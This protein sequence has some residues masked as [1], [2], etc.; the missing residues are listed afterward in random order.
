MKYIKGILFI[1]F[2]IFQTFQSFSQVFFE[3]DFE[4]DGNLPV[5]WTQEYISENYDWRASPGGHTA[6]PGI[7]GSRKPPAAYE[8][9]YNAMFEKLTLTNSVTRFITPE[10]DLTFAIKAQLRFYHA[11]VERCL[12]SGGCNNDRLKVYG[13]Y[14]DELDNVSWVL[15]KTYEEEVAEWTLRTI[16]IPDSLNQN[17]FQLAFE[18]IIGPGWGMC[19]DSVSVIE[20]GL[21]TRYIEK[22]EVKQA[23]TSYVSS[24]TFK[25]PILR[26]DF[27]IKGN[28]G[29]ITLDSL[30]VESLND[31]G[32]NLS[33]DG[34]QIFASEDTIFRD[35]VKLSES[36]D[37]VG[38]EHWF[39]GIDFSFETGLTSIWLTYDMPETISHDLHGAKLDAMIPAGGIRI[40][41]QAYPAQDASPAGFRI[42]YEALFFDDFETDQGWTFTG[43]FEHDIPQ[44]RGGVNYGAPDPDTAH[45]GQKVIGTDLTGLGN[46][47]GDYENDLE[48]D[49]YEAITPLINTEYFALMQF[50][51][52]R[53]LNIEGF[54]TARI[55]YNLNE[56]G[57]W[58]EIWSNKGVIVEER[59]KDVSILLPDTVNFSSSIRLK[60][61][62]GG[63]DLFSVFSGWNIDD[64][65]LVG[66]YISYDLL[67]TEYIESSCDCNHSGTDQITV[68]VTNRG[69]ETASDIPIGFSLDGGNTW[70]MDQIS[71]DISSSDTITYTF[72]ETADF[73]D[74]G[75]YD[76]MVKTFFQDDE[77]PEN[78]LLEHEQFM[79]YQEA[80]PY[81]ANFETD[82]GRWHIKDGNELWERGVPN[83]DVINETATGNNAWTTQLSFN[84]TNNAYALL[85]GP[86]FD[87]SQLEKP[88]F[89]CK[90]WGQ[91]DDANDGLTLMYSADG[92]Q[93]WQPVPGD[94]YYDWNWYNNGMPGPPGTPAWDTSSSGWVLMRTQL[95]DAFD[96]YDYV[97]FG[98]LFTSD[99][100]G[101]D[102]GFAVDDVAI[103]ESP[104]DFTVESLTYPETSCELPDTTHVKVQIENTSLATAP[105][106]TEIPVRFK[107]QGSEVITDTAVLSEDLLP[108]T[109]YEFLFDT[110]VAMDSAGD[111]N[112]EFITL[113][114]DDPDFYGSNNDTTTAIVSVNGMPRYNPF[115]PFTGK[116][117]GSVDLDAGAGYTTYAWNTG[118]DERIFSVFLDGVYTVTVT[119][120]EGCTAVDST[121]V[122][123]STDDLEMTQVITSITNSCLRPDPF[124]IEVEV[125]NRGDEHYGPG[126]E[127]PLAYQLNA[128]EPLEDT[129][130]LVDS[131]HI[132]SS[133]TYTYSQMVDLSQA[134]QH[135]LLI[136]ANNEKDLNR[137]DDTITVV[138]STWGTPQ[139]AITGDTIF[140]SMADTVTI[141][142]GDGF[143]SYTW[144]DASSGRYYDVS[145]N[146]SQWYIVTVDDIHGCGPTSDSVYLNTNDLYLTE[147]VSPDDACEHTASEAPT[148]RVYNNSGNTIQAG[149]NIEFGFSVNGGAPQTEVIALPTVLNG[150]STQSITLSNSMD[151]T[152]TGVY[153]IS[154][155]VNAAEDANKD[156]DTISETVSTL[157]YPDVE[158]M[159]DSIFT[160]QPDTLTFDAGAGFANYL[161]HDGSTSRFFN[162]DQDT[163]FVYSVTVSNSDGCGTDS[164]SVSVFTHDLRLVSIN[165]PVSSCELSD[166][167]LV[168][169]KILNNGSQDLLPGTAIPAAYKLDA[170]SWHNE[171][172]TLTDT[173]AQGQ[174]FFVSFTETVDMSN[175][176]FFTMDAAINFETDANPNNDSVSQ[177]IEVWGLPQ[178]TLNYDYISSTQP[179]TIDLI[180][181]PGTYAGYLWN[182]GVDNDTLSLA[183]YDEPYYSVTVTTINGCSGSDTVYVNS[184]NLSLSNLL[185][186][187]DACA[188]TMNENVTI[189]M[190]NNG[191]DTIPSGSEIDLNIASPETINETLVLS[192]SLAPLDSVDYTFTNTLDLSA[193]G[194]YTLDVSLSADFDANVVDNDI[195]RTIS[196]YGPA[197]VNLGN[198]ITVSSL[199]FVLDAG[200]GFASYLW[201]DNSTSQTFTITENNITGTGLYSVTVTNDLGCEGSDSR[202]VNVNIIDWAADDVLSPETGCYGINPPLLTLRMSNQSSVPVREGRSFFVNY[203]LNGENTEQEVFTL[204]DSVYPQEIY[205]YT[206]NQVPPFNAYE[207]NVVEVSLD[208]A[209][210]INNA[211]DA[212]THTLTPYIPILEFNQ[213]TILPD[214]FPYTIT[215]P[216]GLE[217]YEWNTGALGQNLEV[218]DPGWYTVTAFDNFDCAAMDSVYIVD[219]NALSDLPSAGN[220]IEIW[221]NPVTNQ[222][223]INLNRTTGGHLRYEIVAASG[224]VILT[225]ETNL[226]KGELIELKLDHL[227]KGMYF[228]RFFD[229]DEYG[230]RSLIMK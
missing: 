26:L 105:S 184:K 6:T 103:Y 35:L 19:I 69:V 149:S 20:N 76:I 199:P 116:P 87:L 222:V 78:D 89:E 148:I 228:F 2:T 28:Q 185:A 190:K 179:D 4:H 177:V 151:L 43:E 208:N 127:I 204:T 32:V 79:P 50:N 210:D 54:D 75:W 94:V 38:G 63:T 31:P 97:K 91:I 90:L 188:H 49:A 83:D 200:P 81:F 197:D 139:P 86:C 102:E 84:Y 47:D 65:A 93:N 157:G 13:K 53:W 14:T 144:Q 10:I 41:E 132:D 223:W 9:E 202:R 203:E 27:S 164:D 88:V 150:M 134:R 167:Q 172:Y 146:V 45:S 186:P 215:A 12:I 216:D 80:L 96:S 173:I 7:P 92:C 52:Q 205:D 21:I 67:V 133:I 112:F 37:Y 226:P 121:E 62:L 194:D 175:G 64:L 23:S 176:D 66:N 39:T 214:D 60:F 57:D 137:S 136:Y 225:T 140:S 122:I 71:A 108:N 130:V 72:N 36:G 224:E 110:T 125:T 221:P 48:K 163:S 178:Y 40:E 101:T 126:E 135:T 209:D 5:N 59:W 180:V 211:N 138:T 115:T 17:D 183:A 119:N 24:G 230:N 73:S 187:V 61:A 207:S 56:T 212:I 141:D 198:E 145:S 129:L 109:T 3:E 147:M 111:Y 189:R 117:S 98:F 158:L 118:Y 42:L 120:S 162:A 106:G 44:A 74:G 25:N 154:L 142:A 55:Y 131:L 174:Q 143:D 95:P 170:G 156:N 100:G 206:F 182:V 155:W 22:I 33:S 18:G 171:V 82:D 34:L 29:E 153:N 113:Y 166:Q 68:K 1:A 168:R 107:W 46:R 30:L 220:H 161:W 51:F 229:E 99:A 160:L 192:Q 201:H 227:A 217:D 70:V 159:Y 213:D 165:R 196:T 114:E 58:K 85:E 15:L 169:L 128:Q 11:Q 195:S 193:A 16:N 181:T 104:L 152:D 77:I 8:G 219:P 123:T 191:S 124:S 218:N